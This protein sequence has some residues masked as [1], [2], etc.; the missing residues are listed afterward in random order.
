MMAHLASFIFEGTFERFPT[1]KVLLQEAGVLWV[2]P[3][4]WRL[5]QI[6]MEDRIQLPWMKK[7]PSE[8]FREHVRMS[9][10]PFEATPNRSIFDQSMKSMFAEET[11][12]Y[13]SDYPHWDFD[14]PLQALPKMDDALWDRVLYY[15]AAEYYNLPDRRAE[16]D[17]MPH[18]E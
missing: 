1:L 7:S 5:D 8:Y 2:V 11:L 14:S 18:Q 9:T 10:Q 17:K 3:Y 16:Q 6:W 12:M 13:C 15:N 4:L